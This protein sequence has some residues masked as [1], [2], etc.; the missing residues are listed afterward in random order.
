MLWSNES[1]R[2]RLVR[3]IVMFW[4]VAE[5]SARSAAIFASES[6]LPKNLISVISQVDSA[7]KDSWHRINEAA[8][9]AVIAIVNG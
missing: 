1:S 4:A 7:P 9:E 6:Q 5:L 8:T 2:L 3:V